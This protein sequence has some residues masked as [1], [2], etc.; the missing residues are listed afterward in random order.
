MDKNKLAAGQRCA[1]KVL[2]QF[3]D[4]SIALG[5]RE[6]NGHTTTPLTDWMAATELLSRRG[7]R[8]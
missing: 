3:P 4:L 5:A 8:D 2:T 1:Q 7:D 6:T